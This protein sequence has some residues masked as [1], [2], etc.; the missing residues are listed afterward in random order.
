MKM[1]LK[2]TESLES[3][4]ASLDVEDAIKILSY[5]VLKDLRIK[6]VRKNNRKK[7]I[8]YAIYQAYLDNEEYRDVSHIGKIVGIDASES[9][10]AI[11]CYSKKLS[12][13]FG[14]NSRHHDGIVDIPKMI[15]YYCSSHCL[16]L[17]DEIMN[18]ICEYEKTI[19]NENFSNKIT[20][21]AGIIYSY[22]S[23]KCIYLDQDKCEEIFSVSK[24]MLQDMIR[25]F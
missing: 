15:K 20:Y 17:S 7:V 10:H 16:D 13:V 5:V 2:N 14:E 1:S 24:K 9:K 3:E 21:C 6:S 22:A 18:D 25:Q 12:N 4:I 23:S 19:N 11:T 8:V